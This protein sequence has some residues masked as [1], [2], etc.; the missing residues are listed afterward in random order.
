MV[1][2]AKPNRQNQIGMTVDIL[3]WASN[4]IAPCR[5]FHPAMKARAAIVPAVIWCPEV[6]DWKARENLE[7]VTHLKRSNPLHALSQCF[8]TVGNRTKYFGH[9]VRPLFPWPD[10]FCPSFG[11]CLTDESGDFIGMRKH[12][13]VA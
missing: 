7:G 1:V 9:V 4:K 13:H 10:L 12:G 8:G 6:P 5:K 2:N 3:G 11:G